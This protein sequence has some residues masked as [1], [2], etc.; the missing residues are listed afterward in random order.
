[1][2]QA[3]ISILFI[4]QHPS[5]KL[6]T[7]LRR[8]RCW[9]GYVLYSILAPSA[10][11]NAYRKGELCQRRTKESFN[12][13]GTP[14]QLQNCL[15]G[16]STHS[17]KGQLQ[18]GTGKSTN[19]VTKQDVSQENRFHKNVLRPRPISCNK[20]L[21]QSQPKPTFFFKQDSTNKE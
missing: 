9:A 18:S 16:L 11:H 4:R 8:L 17:N 2:A 3:S 19:K 13:Q 15:K 14:P 5:T 10:Q 7:P 21:L 1:M 12:C 6:P 20:S